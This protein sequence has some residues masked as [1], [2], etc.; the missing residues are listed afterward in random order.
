MGLPRHGRGSIAS[1]IS[2]ALSFSTDAALCHSL[3]LFFA[4]IPDIL[5]TL[6]VFWV[7]QMIVGSIGYSFGAILMGIRV[8]TLEGQRPGWANGVMRASMTMCV[9]PALVL[10]VD[11]RAV[12]DRACQTIVLRTR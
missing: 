8:Q 7:Y 3:V 11:T 10:D 5:T 4:P 9:L 6:L 12:H 2:R 1:P